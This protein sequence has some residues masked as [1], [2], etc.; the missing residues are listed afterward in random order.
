MKRGKRIQE[1][2]NQMELQLKEMELH[3]KGT[4]NQITDYLYLSSKLTKFANPQLLLH[5][6]KSLESHKEGRSKVHFFDYDGFK[7]SIVFS[8]GYEEKFFVI[9]EYIESGLNPVMYLEEKRSKYAESE[10]ITAETRQKIKIGLGVLLSSGKPTLTVRGSDGSVINI[11]TQSLLKYINESQEKTLE[12]INFLST[13]CSSDVITVYLNHAFS[14]AIAEK[15]LDFA[16][17]ILEYAMEHG[18]DVALIEEYFT[19][20]EGIFSV[21]S[22]LIISISGLKFDLVEKILN[23]AIRDNLRILASYSDTQVL[24]L[25]QIICNGGDLSIIEKFIKVCQPDLSTPIISG[26][27]PAFLLVEV[28]KSTKIKNK[29]EILKLLLEKGADPNI[30]F[31]TEGGCH[32]SKTLLIQCVEDNDI[33]VAELLINNGADVNFLFTQGIYPKET[34]Q[35]NEYPAAIAAALANQNRAMIKLLLK[36]GSKL[37]IVFDHKGKGYI[38]VDEKSEAKKDNAILIKE[39]HKLICEATIAIFIDKLEAKLLEH[40][41]SRPE[42]AV[43]EDAGATAPGVDQPLTQHAST[44]SLDRGEDVASV[45][46]GRDLILTLDTASQEVVRNMLRL[47][48]QINNQPTIDSQIKSILFEVL[49]NNG[50]QQEKLALL[51][52]RLSELSVAHPSE[53]SA[54]IISIAHSLDRKIVGDTKDFIVTLATDPRLVHQY[55]QGE[56]QSILQKEQGV[57]HEEPVKWTIDGEKITMAT[58]HL[59][60]ISSNT[61]DKFFIYF[62]KEIW[63]H[64]QSLLSKLDGINLHFITRDSRGENGVKISKTNIAKLKLL[65]EGEGG[66]RFTS[67]V[68]VKNADGDTLIVFNKCH[69]HDDAYKYARKKKAEHVFLPHT[70]DGQDGDAA[71]Q[72]DTGSN[73]GNG[74]DGGG[75]RGKTAS[76]DIGGAK[77]DYTS[78][79]GIIVAAPVQSQTESLP[80]E[81]EGEND[82]IALVAYMQGVSVSALKYIL[83]NNEVMGRAMQ[84]IIDALFNVHKS[85]SIADRIAEVGRN[86]KLSLQDKADEDNQKSA[87][88]DSASPALSITSGSDFGAFFSIYNDPL[89]QYHAALGDSEQLI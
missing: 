51:N 88:E 75:A 3:L 20:H 72:G 19:N 10:R 79:N 59:Y 34:F 78:E 21:D 42:A 47:Y 65:K 46:V 38:C 33:E 89:N 16:S 31:P 32:T 40:E 74:G 50:S 30:L 37:P 1:Y 11:R 6:I 39:V 61:K 85:Y 62:S 58:P 14:N 18:V 70:E 63:D 80:A 73:N 67:D 82:A 48:K 8:D 64:N 66:K 24:F 86:F 76:F 12:L 52:E 54:A 71:G 27:P 5:L 9:A 25:Y 15:K 23:D 53:T 77:A 22:P 26:D 44:A 2:K 36:R 49:S 81:A 57:A 68:W 60:E 45:S 29:F 17:L 7:I 28:Y 41:V 55:C 69:A 83:Q 43:A 13:E 87:E 56:L 4:L 84:K 35:V